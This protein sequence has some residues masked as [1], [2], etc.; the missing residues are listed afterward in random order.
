M[1]FIFLKIERVVNFYRLI[2]FMSFRL[3]DYVY[4]MRMCV[5]ICICYYIF[6]SVKD[7][8]RNFFKIV[9]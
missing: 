1:F 9:G 7:I 8:S 2:V 4:I 6:K 5:Y 3:L